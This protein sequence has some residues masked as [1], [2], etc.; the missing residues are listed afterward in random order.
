MLAGLDFR[1][2][3]TIGDYI[4]LVRFLNC[5]DTP[6]RSRGPCVAGVPDEQGLALCHALRETCIRGTAGGAT[7]HY[8]ADYNYRALPE[9]LRQGTEGLADDAW[10]KT[11]TVIDGTN[12]PVSCGMFIGGAGR[13]GIVAVLRKSNGHM[14]AR[15]ARFMLSVHESR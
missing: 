10:G 6:G 5:G 15:W 3:F 14:T 11:A 12:R 1:L 4:K 9:S 7:K 13:R 2:T 8:G